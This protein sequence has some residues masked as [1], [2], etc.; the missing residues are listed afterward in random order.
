MLG[1]D[2]LIDTLPCP[3]IILI[4]CDKLA[5]CFLTK[6]YKTEGIHKRLADLPN[7]RTQHSVDYV[8]GQVV[9]HS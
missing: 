9:D 8:D 4:L 2:I 7:Q 5:K 1:L 3:H 6:I